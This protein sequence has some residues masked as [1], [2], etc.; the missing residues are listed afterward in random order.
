MF[1]KKTSEDVI[2]HFDSSLEGLSQMEVMKRLKQNGPN[3]LR[4]KEKVPTWKLFLES[5]K[6]PLVIILLIAALVQIFL[7]EVV[8]SVIIFA[9]LILNSI[10]E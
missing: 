2:K 7:G 4:E 9:V 1:Y 8:E 10:L 3:E 6:D 5:F